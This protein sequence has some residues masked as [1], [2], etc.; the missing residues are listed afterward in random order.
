MSIK[1]T[2]VNLEYKMNAGIC[3]KIKHSLVRGEQVD[4]FCTKTK[5]TSAQF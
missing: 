5:Q 3:S 1:Y 2:K 4:K